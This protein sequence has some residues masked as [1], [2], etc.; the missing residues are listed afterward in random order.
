MKEDGENKE[1]EEEEKT[2]WMPQIIIIFY[3]IGGNQEVK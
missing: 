1:G 3:N 2:Q